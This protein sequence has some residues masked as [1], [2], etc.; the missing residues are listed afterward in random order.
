M[1]N[2]NRKVCNKNICYCHIILTY[3][4]SICLFLI[5][6]IQRSFDFNSVVLRQT[7]TMFLEKLQLNNERYNI[8]INKFSIYSLSSKKIYIKYFSSNKNKK[9]NLSE[10]IS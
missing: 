1:L 4:K 2:W 7:I 9:V 3:S 8:T 6:I 5:G 10:I